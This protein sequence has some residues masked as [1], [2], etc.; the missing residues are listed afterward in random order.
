MWNI[1]LKIF[2][3]LDYF[4]TNI[5]EGTAHRRKP[6]GRSLK[7]IFQDIQNTMDCLSI[8]ETKEVTNVSKE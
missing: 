6:R 2:L 1:S 5:F 7:T 4:N 3:R 8:I